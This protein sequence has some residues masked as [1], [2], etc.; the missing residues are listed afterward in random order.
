[1]QLLLESQQQFVSR[2]SGGWELP[3]P[4]SDSRPLLSLCAEH[5][6][7]HNKRLKLETE[8]RVRKI[9]KTKTFQEAFHSFFFYKCM[10]GNVGCWRTGGWTVSQF[11][12]CRLQAENGI[13]PTNVGPV[14]APWSDRHIY[15]FWPKWPENSLHLCLVFTLRKK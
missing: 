11:W 12:R 1:M 15:E 13:R 6:A 10:M 4:H 5:T 8:G 3:A 9:S 2:V 7:L 14:L